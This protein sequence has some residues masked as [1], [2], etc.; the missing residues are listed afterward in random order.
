MTNNSS[1]NPLEEPHFTSAVTVL[2]TLK[3]NEQREYQE[4]ICSSS[5]EKLN[6][7]LQSAIKQ[8]A[9]VHSSENFNNSEVASSCRMKPMQGGGVNGTNNVNYSSSK[10]Q[11]H[12]KNGGNNNRQSAEWKVV[13]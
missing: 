13:K 8:Q 4:L 6:E 10:Q 3:S 12:M 1:Q 9:H 2:P 7:K 5:D 11:Q